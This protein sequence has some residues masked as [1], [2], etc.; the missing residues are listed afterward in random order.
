[1]LTQDFQLHL[2]PIIHLSCLE[3]NLREKRPKF[4]VP[5]FR[6]S[7]IGSLLRSEKNST[8]GR[9]WFVEPRETMWNPRKEQCWLLVSTPLKHTSQLGLLFPIYGNVSEFHFC[10]LVSPFGWYSSPYEINAMNKGHKWAWLLW[11]SSI[12]ASKLGTRIGYPTLKL[13]ETGYQN[14]VPDSQFWPTIPF[15]S[16]FGPTKLDFSISGSKTSTI[17]WLRSS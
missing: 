15:H 7:P 12:K 9:I 13:N 14:S 8:V 1:M 5:K 6:G 4:G 11:L 3:R 16:W 2:H 17:I 10:W